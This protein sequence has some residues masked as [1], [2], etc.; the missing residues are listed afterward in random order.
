MFDELY[1]GTNPEEAII[2]A[3]VVMDY[4][5][6]RKNVTTILT[7]HYVELCSKL[8]NNDQIKNC[9]MKVLQNKDNFEYT[10]LIANGISD[11]KGGIKVLIDMDYPQ[12]IIDKAK[13]N[14]FVQ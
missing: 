10:Y 13:L 14:K 11:V 4:L 8:E 1:S 2:S 12:E 3:Y 9:H 5:A 6:K 7:T